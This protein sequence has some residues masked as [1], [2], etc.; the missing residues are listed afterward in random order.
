MTHQQNTTQPARFAIYA[1]FSS[2]M[3]NEVSLESQEMMCRRSVTERGGVVTKVYTDAAKLGWSLDR[4]QF[5]QLRADAAN[6]KFVAVIMCK[7]DR[8][9][10]DLTQTTMI[11]ALLRHEYGLKLYCVEGYSEDD[12]NSPYT[13]LMEQMLAVFSAFYSKN[14]STEVKRSKQHGFENGHYHGSTPPLGYYLATNA[15]SKHPRSFRATNEYPIGIYVH[16]RGAALVR[17]AFKMYATGEHSF[18]TIAEFLNR[19]L[20]H[21]KTLNDKP[22]SAEM[23]R[24][25][26][27]NKLY[28]GYVSYAEHLYKDR[29]GQGSVSRRGRVAWG[30]GIHQAIISEQLFEEVQSVRIWK[31]KNQRKP[32]KRTYLLEGKCY[33]WYCLTSNSPMHRQKAHGRMRG[34]QNGTYIYYRCVSEIRGYGECPQCM[35]RTERIEQN[36]IEVLCSLN[37]V[38]SHD[39]H[40]LFASV[41]S[42]R[43]ETA[44]AMGR[45]EEILKEIERIDFSWQKGWMTQADYIQKRQQLQHDI[46]TSRSLDYD[47]FV[48]GAA[49]LRDF[50]IHWEKCSIIKEQMELL[51]K[52]IERVIVKDNKIH[53]IILR[54]G[55][56]FMVEIV[57][58]RRE[59][60]SN[61]RRL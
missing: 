55:F 23:V 20:K 40:E 34:T 58:E 45:M 25:L 60:D 51:D 8:L 2:E 11:K 3:Q 36:L 19:H 44:K 57:S 13:A 27:Q 48:D 6:V 28:A 56:S 54:G 43:L 52:V 61:P 14:L 35:V 12:D 1:R 4:E 53:S 32:R 47:K 49:L 9:A 7:F 50:K 46:E 38:L 24:E 31:G 37:S 15:P 17:R 59:R 18:K 10:R 41:I 33:C 16:P 5:N 29:F 22:V 39:I 42:E 26:L 30:K 21:L